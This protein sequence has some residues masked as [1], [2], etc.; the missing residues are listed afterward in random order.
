MK[1]KSGLQ[2]QQND[3]TSNMMQSIDEKKTS[4][5]MQY[6]W[7]AYPLD[8]ILLGYHYYRNDSKMKCQKNMFSRAISSC[9]ETHWAMF[10]ANKE[11]SQYLALTNV[12]PNFE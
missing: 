6:I 11:T 9:N 10:D 2:L 7:P 12:W 8:P 4:I 5:D 3:I 1:K